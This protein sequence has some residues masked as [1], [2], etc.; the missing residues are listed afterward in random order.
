M[1]SDQE[2]AALIHALVG[3]KFYS[4]GNHD[5]DRIV[6]LVVAVV[7]AKQRP[8][9]SRLE[10]LTEAMC[11]LTDVLTTVALR[12]GVAPGNP[13]YSGP[14]PTMYRGEGSEPIPAG[15]V[16]DM[17]SAGGGDSN[18]GTT[19]VPTGET[20]SVEDAVARLRALQGG[21]ST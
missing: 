21:S 13:L 9:E 1:A 12:G 3:E 19:T 11:R 15:L 18:L 17:V 16:A 14:Q 5:R 4:I 20:T 8:V 7:D 6:A 10:G 2:I